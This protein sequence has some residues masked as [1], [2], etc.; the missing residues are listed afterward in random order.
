MLDRLDPLVEASSSSPARIGTASWA[1]IGP[2]SRVASTRWT[3]APGDRD[4]GGE[5]VAHRMRA[6]ERRQERR[7]G[8][9]DPARERR[10]R[11]P[12]EDPQVAGQDDEIGLRGGQGRRQLGVLGGPSVAIVRAAAGMSAVSIPCSAAQSRAGQAGRRR[13]GQSS[14][15]ARRGRRRRRGPAGSSRAPETPTAIRRPVG[16]HR[17]RALHVA[18]A[19]EVGSR[20]RPR[21]RA[22]PGSPRPRASAIVASTA[23]GVNDEDHPEAAVERRPELVVL[24]PAEGA[25]QPHHRRHRPAAGIEPRA[26]SVRQRPRHVARQA[27]AGDVG[28]PAQV[29]AGRLERGPE[30]EDRPGVDA[31]RGRAGPRRASPARGRARRPARHRV[32]GSPS[33]RRS[34][35]W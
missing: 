12:A 13:R 21:R 7:M 26:E 35:S 1:T 24:E 2:P 31:G 18:S 34:R 3:V 28:D 25:E 10:Q 9:E 17:I 20:R 16:G 14:R 32:A 29:V 30:P 23:S 8:V 19:A 22:R 5:R 15:R 11:R 27:A 33:D 4:S 6:G